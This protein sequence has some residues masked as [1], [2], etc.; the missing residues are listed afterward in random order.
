[1]KKTVYSGLS[2]KCLIMTSCVMERQPYNENRAKKVMEWFLHSSLGNGT[3][4][5]LSGLGKMYAGGGSFTENIDK[6][7]GGGCAEFAANAIEIYCR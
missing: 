6:A 1:M 4:E 5:I 7:G 2:T 3:K